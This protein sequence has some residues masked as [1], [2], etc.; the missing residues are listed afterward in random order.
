MIAVWIEPHE[1]REA[2]E[3]YRDWLTPDFIEKIESAPEAA[4]IRISRN[5][6]SIAIAVIE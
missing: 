5:D 1:R 6:G 2:I 4:R 3:A